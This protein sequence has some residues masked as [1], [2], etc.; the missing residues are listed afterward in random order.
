MN[1]A[2]NI[3]LAVRRV[4]Q[5]IRARSM[6]SHGTLGQRTAEHL[7]PKDGRATSYSDM[8]NLDG[9]ITPAVRRVRQPIRARSIDSRGTLVQS[10]DSVG[11]FLE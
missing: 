9:I 1:L 5:P 11:A 3:A 2:G 10:L 8:M 4:R 6:D 7:G